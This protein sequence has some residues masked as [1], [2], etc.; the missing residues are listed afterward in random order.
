MNPLR[1]EVLLEELLT[2][3]QDHQ[4][5]RDFWDEMDDTDRLL[6]R[7]R[8][9]ACIKASAEEQGV[10][11]GRRIAAEFQEMHGDRPDYKDFDSFQQ[12]VAKLSM[13]IKQ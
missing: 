5:F 4:E 2:C 13:G 1:N 3:L 11:L 9:I 8:M 10:A 7:S 6:L 12:S